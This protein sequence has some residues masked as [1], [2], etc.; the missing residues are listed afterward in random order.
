MF[1]GTSFF[2]GKHTLLPPATNVADFKSLSISDGKYDRLYLTANSSETLETIDNG[3]LF[4]TKLDAK[5]DKDLEAGSIGFSVRNTDTIVIKTREKGTFD[6]RTIYTI[7]IENNEDLNFIKNYAYSR[8]LSTNEYMLISMINGI[9]NSYVITEE[10][11]EFDG[12]FIVDKDN[13]YGTIFNIQSTDTIQNINVST[14]PLLNDRYPSVYTNADT[15]YTSGT[16]SGCWLK[17]DFEKNEVN[18]ENSVVYRQEV[19]QW[20]CNGKSKILKLEDGRIFLIKVVGTPSDSSDGH[21]ELRRISFDWVE[22]G[23]VNDMRTLYMNNLTDIEEK[24]W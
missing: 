21:K 23:D 8:N 2:C 12:Y 24:Y 14:L 7:P 20:I 18:I 15:N 16:T 6:W 4:D 3:W 13:I 11:T 9:E 22:I 10:K 5:F 17:F 1:L 19:M